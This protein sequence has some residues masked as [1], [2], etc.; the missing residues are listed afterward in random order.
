MRL[1]WLETIGWLLVAAGGAALVSSV[2]TNDDVLR[3]MAS[4]LSLGAIGVF[5][6]LLFERAR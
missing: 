1:L 3:R 5:V 2:I 6:I 4:A